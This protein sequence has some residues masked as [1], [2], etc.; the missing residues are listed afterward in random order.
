MMAQPLFGDSLQRD[1]DVVSVEFTRS[2]LRRVLALLSEEVYA[3]SGERI[4]FT[5]TE[6]AAGRTTISVTEFQE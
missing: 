3:A 1:D 5:A 2:A 6:P 4:E